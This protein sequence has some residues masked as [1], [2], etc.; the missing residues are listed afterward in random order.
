MRFLANE[1]LPGDA[2]TALEA[3]EREPAMHR[4]AA[5][6]GDG[7]AEGRRKLRGI[8]TEHHRG[9]RRQISSGTETGVAE[10]AMADLG[11]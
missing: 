11:E 9:L 4:L 6:Y 5:E 8:R 3:A 2:V 7:C 10:K 1:N